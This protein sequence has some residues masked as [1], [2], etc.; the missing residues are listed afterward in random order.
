MKKEIK[1]RKIQKQDIKGEGQD[2]EN[3]K[4]KWNKVRSNNRTERNT[5]TGELMNKKTQN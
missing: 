2:E 1:E 4:K 5:K 3:E